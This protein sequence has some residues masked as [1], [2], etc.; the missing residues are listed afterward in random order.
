M[1]L[2]Y[3]N[4]FFYSKAFLDDLYA[5]TP[6]LIIMLFSHTSLSSIFSIIIKSEKDISHGHQLVTTKITKSEYK[7]PFYYLS[8]AVVYNTYQGYFSMLDSIL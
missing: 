2:E 1:F 8:I 7:K 5:V 3:Q 6:V 4:V